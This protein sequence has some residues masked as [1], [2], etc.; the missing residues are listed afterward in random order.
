MAI[1]F[2]FPYGTGQTTA[3][4][5]TKPEA[6]TTVLSQPRP[7]EAPLR[8]HARRGHAITP[9]SAGRPGG[10]LTEAGPHT[11]RACRRRPASGTFAFTVDVHADA[12][13]GAPALVRRR[14]RR[15]ARALEPLLVH[16]RRHRPLGQHRTRAGGSSSAASCCRSTS[17]PSSAPAGIPPQES[18]LTFN[19]WEGKF[20]LEM[21]WWHAAQFALWDRLPLLERSLGYYDAILPKARAARRRAR[22]TPARAG[23]R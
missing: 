21:H 4:D 9:R 1:E 20:H 7:D 13:G 22:A 10:T 5:W 16:R 19:S 2:R 3:A 18:G 15:G 12:A 6:H 11:H 8:P 14:Q 23:R 17:R